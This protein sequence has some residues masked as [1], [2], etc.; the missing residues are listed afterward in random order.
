MSKQQAEKFSSRDSTHNQ[1][2]TRK[3][4]QRADRDQVREQKTCSGCSNARTLK[5]ALSATDARNRTR[6]Q[7]DPSYQKRQNIVSL[8]LGLIG[9]YLFSWNTNALKRTDENRQAP[10]V[11]RCTWKLLSGMSS[12]ISA[13]PNAGAPLR[14]NGRRRFFHVRTMVSFVL[15]Y[16]ALTKWSI[17]LSWWKAAHRWASENDRKLLRYSVTFTTGTTKSTQVGTPSWKRAE[18]LASPSLTKYP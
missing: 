9:K 6:L 5:E 8:V 4:V 11:P 10:N 3:R 7:G 13:D 12:F 18:P 1:S 14:F 16:W 17:S 2:T 15:S